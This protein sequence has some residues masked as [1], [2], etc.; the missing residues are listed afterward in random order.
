MSL[1]LRGCERP[2]RKSDEDPG[3][4]IVTNRRGSQ[5]SPIS[6]LAAVGPDTVTTRCE[7]VKIAF[8]GTPPRSECNEASC[9]WSLA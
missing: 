2:S 6:G 7:F 3:C 9:F 8:C 1:Q 4:R 5:A